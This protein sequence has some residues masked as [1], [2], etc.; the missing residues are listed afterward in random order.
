ML[1]TTFNNY[2]GFNNP[3]IEDLMGVDLESKPSHKSLNLYLDVGFKVPL[4]NF[5]SDTS[6]LG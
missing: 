2:S 1:N 3:Y 4:I 6:K 5:A